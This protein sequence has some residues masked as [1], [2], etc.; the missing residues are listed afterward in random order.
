MS[1]IITGSVDFPSNRLLQY[2]VQNETL[3][4]FDPYTLS[5]AL[6]VDRSTG[7][8]LY[9]CRNFSQVYST[10]DYTTSNEYTL[11]IGGRIKNAK[12]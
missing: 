6:A 8:Q 9:L 2:L 11:L 4:T 3:N 10:S 5:D 12:L 1:M 7:V